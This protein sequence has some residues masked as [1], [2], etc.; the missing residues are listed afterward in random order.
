MASNDG[1]MQERGNSL[2]VSIRNINPW[3]QNVTNRHLSP[4][5]D[6]ISCLLKLYEKNIAK[7]KLNDCI[8]AIGILEFKGAKEQEKKPDDEVDQIVESTTTQN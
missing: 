4:Q 8:T 6:G 5:G 2:G 7:F 3:V 1:F